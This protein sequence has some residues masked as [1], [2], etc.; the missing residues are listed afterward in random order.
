MKT[1]HRLYPVCNYLGWGVAHLF[2]ALV[3]L[4]MIVMFVLYA[5]M[6]LSS[7]GNWNNA[8]DRSKAMGKCIERP[9]WWVRSLGGMLPIT[10]PQN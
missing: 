6:E 9:L 10:P 4:P 8:N 1:T 5:L 7:T 2:A 3:I